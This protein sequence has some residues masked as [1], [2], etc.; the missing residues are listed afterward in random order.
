[1][2]I[3]DVFCEIEIHKRKARFGWKLG[4][5]RRSVPSGGLGHH[6]RLGR[7]PPAVLERRLP[8]W[9]RVT[10]RNLRGVG[11]QRVKLARTAA[12]NE[13]LRRVWSIT[14]SRSLTCNVMTGLVT[15]MPPGRSVDQPAEGL[16]ASYSPLRQVGDAAGVMSSQPGG[17]RFRHSPEWLSR[18]ALERDCLSSARVRR[19]GL[20]P[21]T[22]G[23]KVRCS[24]S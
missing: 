13:P 15:V 14:F 8:I 5:V 19:Q 11:W 16:W 2:G 12:G 9:D 21:R 20:E 17:R 24:A 10:A 23:L 18:G 1:M 3:D 7:G 4:A 22:H 6:R